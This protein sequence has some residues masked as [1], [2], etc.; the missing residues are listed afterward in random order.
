MAFTETARAHKVSGFDENV[1][2]GS[3]CFQ[4]LLLRSRG[5]P[6]IMGISEEKE[7]WLWPQGMSI[8]WICWISSGSS[9]HHQTP[10]A[11]S[12]GLH[13]FTVCVAIK[14]KFIPTCFL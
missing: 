5:G 3:K 14:K 2:G 12:V 8:P 9:F 11:N 7:V 1:C 13:M 4:L 10:S 6:A